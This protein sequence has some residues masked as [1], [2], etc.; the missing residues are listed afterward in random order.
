MK[1]ELPCKVIALTGE[2]DALS[3]LVL[4][5][6]ATVRAPS[7]PPVLHGATWCGGLPWYAQETE[8]D[9]I[10]LRSAR[11]VKVISGVSPS[12]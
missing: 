5:F 6:R 11:D 4:G 8:E 10:A 3:F 12:V 9:Q 1:C 7:F 2:L